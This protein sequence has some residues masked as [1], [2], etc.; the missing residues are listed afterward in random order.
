MTKYLEP[1]LTRH[2]TESN[3]GLPISCR[4]FC[5]DPLK[6]TTCRNLN[7]KAVRT[8]YVQ[9][10]LRPAS[11]FSFDA[12]GRNAFIYKIVEGLV[13]IALRL[14]SNTTYLIKTE[15]AQESERQISI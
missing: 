10:L 9:I 8:L 15:E 3:V 12:I 4:P 1:F 11:F 5:Y 2:Y 13:K 6:P 14:Y 7:K